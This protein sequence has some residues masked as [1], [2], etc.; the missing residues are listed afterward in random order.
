MVN[1]EL[2]KMF[3]KARGNEAFRRAAQAAPKSA[4][5]AR[6][7]PRLSVFLRVLCVSVVKSCL[8]DLPDLPVNLPLVSLCLGGECFSFFDQRRTTTAHEVARP[9]SV[10][11]PP[12]S[13]APNP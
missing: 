9:S 1:F 4:E 13:F 8:P 12:S 7:A 6:K 5:G 3:I 11:R 10:C 2:R